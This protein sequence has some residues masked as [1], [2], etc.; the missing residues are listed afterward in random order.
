[1]SIEST[2]LESIDQ[3]LQSVVTEGAHGKHID[4]S[5]T[6]I[7]LD[8][9]ER[10]STAPV[11]TLF[12]GTVATG[13]NEKKWRYL[14]TGDGSAF[15]KDSNSPT[16]SLTAGTAD[17]CRVV[18]QGFYYA[19]YQ[20]GKMQEILISFRFAVGKANVSQRV[21]WF[22]NDNGLYL[23]L[24]GTS[25][26]FVRRTKITGSV[27]DNA[28]PRNEWSD[29][30]DGSV[31]EH[32]L[33][34]E[35]SHLMRI[36]FG[37]L[38]VAGYIVSFYVDGH[39]H[40]ALFYKGTNDAGEDIAWT[41]NPNLPARYEIINT[42]VAAS[43]TSF[44]TICADINSIGGYQ[45]QL[46]PA[47]VQAYPNPSTVRQVNGSVLGA[48]ISIRM[49]AGF[50]GV[51]GKPLDFSV[52][53]SGANVRIVASIVLNGTITDPTW[54]S[55]GDSSP[56]EIFIPGAT[57]T[58]SNI[59]GGTILKS[60]VFDDGSFNADLFANVEQYLSHGIDSAAAGDIISLVVSPSGNS[61]ITAM[62]NIGEIQ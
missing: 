44:R 17:G 36:V 51:L 24:A 45:F 16:V 34:M 61:D 10:F 30:L 3:R 57:I 15:T 38:G 48:L 20:P 19:P 6:N 8:L 35:G 23:E 53:K 62:F 56:F 59:T 21:G 43:P 18:R 29:P 33:D 55:L 26:R 31:S 11:Q 27:V 4:V 9:F 52:R 49:K 7:E 37:W 32:T 14:A 5:V 1:M 50:S 54:S 46:L 25:L 41:V 42:G 60:W 28:T 40:H 12:A 39:W 47:T 13:L 58:S 22:D 2:K